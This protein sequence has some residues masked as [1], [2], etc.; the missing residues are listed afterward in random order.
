MSEQSVLT[1]TDERGVA[2]LTLN[3]PQLHNAFDEQL[4][5]ALT[6]AIRTLD[7]DR[8]VRVLRLTGAGASFSAGADLNWMRRMASYS[9]QD[10]LR[11]A[12]QL[13]ELMRTLNRTRTPSVAVVQGPAYGGGVGLVCCCDVAVASTEASFCLSEVKLGLI[14]SVIAPYV[15][16]AMGRRAA[17]RYMITAERIEAVTARELGLVHEVAA[18]E[19]LDGAAERFAR[20]LLNNGPGAIA[21]TKDLVDAVAWRGVDEAVVTDTAKR[22]AEQRASTEGREGVAAFLEKRKP[23]WV[24]G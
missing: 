5:A 3:R 15:V 4:I 9:V 2:T 14:P 13:A 7:A 19:A 24:K 10:N 12:M 16:A 17:Q 8:N 1:Q 18:P 20:A 21:A 11:D 23:G 22:I 6:E